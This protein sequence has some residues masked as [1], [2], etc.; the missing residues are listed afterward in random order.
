MIVKAIEEIREASFLRE[1]LGVLMTT[2]TH[3]ELDGDGFLDSLFK[4]MRTVNG[5]DADTCY[6]ALPASTTSAENVR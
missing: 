2:S 6:A 3:R 5:Q 4:H 1:T